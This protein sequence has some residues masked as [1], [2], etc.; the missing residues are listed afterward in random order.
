[1]R[2]HIRATLKDAEAL[3]GDDRQ[4]AFDAADKLTKDLDA[5]IAERNTLAHDAD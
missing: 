4:K 5:L 2:E 3:R 1:M